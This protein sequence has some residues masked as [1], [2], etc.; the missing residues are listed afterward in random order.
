MVAT[1]ATLQRRRDSGRRPSAWPLA[2]APRLPATGV[3]GPSA[4]RVPA[5]VAHG[6][7]CGGATRAGIGFRR[8]SVN[9][10]ARTA[11]VPLAPVPPAR[12]P[13]HA[14]RRP[15]ASSV[16]IGHRSHDAGVAQHHATC[17]KQGRAH[18]HIHTRAR[19]STRTHTRTRTRTCALSPLHRPVPT[20]RTSSAAPRP[21]QPA[22][23]RAAAADRAR[24]LLGGA[25]HG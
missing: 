14:S 10:R 4:S 13:Q 20:R 8:R 11:T 24:Q 7:R 21:Q 2:H 18:M 9:K 22:P 3:V 16:R 17:G 19:R 25:D 6:A 15:A 23:G 5:A 1:A 12:A